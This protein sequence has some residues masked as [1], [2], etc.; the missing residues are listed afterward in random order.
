[1]TIIRHC[2]LRPRGKQSGEAL[3]VSKVCRSKHGTWHN[4]S[5][6]QP[7]LTSTILTCYIVY[8]ALRF[9][10]NCFRSAYKKPKSHNIVLK[11]WSIMAFSI[12]AVVPAIPTIHSDRDMF[13]CCLPR[14][15]TNQPI[16]CLEN[17]TFRH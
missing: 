2:G 14:L 8:A 3:W 10:E 4:K 15:P 12:E 1:M 11:S 9:H 16:T 7:A 17:G 6:E 5:K 13:I